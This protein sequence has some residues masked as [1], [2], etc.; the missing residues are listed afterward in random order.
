MTRVLT[1]WLSVAILASLALSLALAQD[2]VVEADDPKKPEVK[3]PVVVE[4]DPEQI[5]TQAHTLVQIVCDLDTTDTTDTLYIWTVVKAKSFAGQYPVT[6]EDFDF[7]QIAAD[8]KLVIA[9]APP[10]CYEIKCDLVGQ[11]ADGLTHAMR[12]W[13]VTIQGERPPPEPEPNDPENPEDPDTDTDANR[14]TY[15]YEKEKAFVPREVAAALR[16]LNDAEGS[17]IIAAA[18][19]Q[20]AVTGTLISP[21]QYEI[22]IAA[23]K[24]AGVPALVVQSG[25]TVIR[26][27]K[28]PT[29]REA[30]MNAID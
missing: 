5:V 26:V 16:E 17:D 3:L 10:G 19:D 2:E 12:S 11:T 29:T 23:A 8:P 14:V 7:T 25:D 15:V 21:K 4:A 9:T 13:E 24:A 28:D 27:V 1:V 6:Q 22:A 18:I 30:V 20:D